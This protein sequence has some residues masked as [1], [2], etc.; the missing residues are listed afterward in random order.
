LPASTSPTPLRDAQLASRL[1]RVLSDLGQDVWVDTLAI[2]PGDDWRDVLNDALGKSDVV[3]ALLTPNS[4]GSKW[5]LSELGA[6]RAYQRIRGD[7]AILPIVIGDAEIPGPI[8]DIQAIVARDGNLEAIAPRVLQAVNQLMGLQAAKKVERQAIQERI[9]QNA[10]VYVEEALRSL[11]A[12]ESRYKRVAATRYGLGYLSLLAGIGVVIIYTR[13]ALDGLANPQWPILIFL[14]IKNIIIIGLL[15]ACSKYAFSLGK[16]YMNEALKNSD[17]S[18][19]IS[20]GK[21][22]LGA[23]GD[24]ATWTELKDVFQ[25]WNIVKESSFL[26]IDSKDFDPNFIASAIE[27]GKVIAN[28]AP[29]RGK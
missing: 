13:A 28:Q 16:S 21:F 26:S 12:R 4:V 20:F 10:S 19:A 11:S 29:L 17:R 27:I 3:I 1:A 7:I 24:K 23:Y 25:H 8:S 18:H 6:A 22:Y 15:V 14:A 9:E 5:M 2:L